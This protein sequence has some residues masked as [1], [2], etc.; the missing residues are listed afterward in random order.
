[1]L[2]GGL[3]VEG[4]VDTFVCLRLEVACSELFQTVALRGYLQ[5]G[6]CCCW[7]LAGMLAAGMLAGRT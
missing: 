4:N 3:H 7:L 5:L 1:M 2:F 6:I